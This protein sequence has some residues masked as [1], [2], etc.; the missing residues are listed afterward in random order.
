MIGNGTQVLFAHIEKAIEMLNFRLLFEANPVMTPRAARWGGV[1]IILLSGMVLPIT[2]FLLV[3]VLE[4]PIPANLLPEGV[5]YDGPLRSGPI[6]GK[7]LTAAG[8]VVGTV[9]LSAVVALLQGVWMA[10]LG[11]RNW[12]LLRVLMVL[13]GAI[14][15]AGVVSSVMLGRRFGQVG[16]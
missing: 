6:W 10:V 13:V 3:I 5:R 15:L 11:R 12:V 2:A 16:Q 4:V 1:V 14:L 9:S 8:L 7:L